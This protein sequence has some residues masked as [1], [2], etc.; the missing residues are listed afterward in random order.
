M[1]RSNTL[2]WRR[3]FR[4]AFMKCGVW[5]SVGFACFVSPDECPVGTFSNPR[6]LDYPS[7][8]LSPFTITT[9]L[10]TSISVGCIIC[11]K[12]CLPREKAAGGLKLTHPPPFRAWI[13]MNNT[14]APLFDFVSCTGTIVPTKAF[15]R[16]ERSVPYVET[17]CVCSS[18]T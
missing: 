18:V 3:G 2:V 9:F 4:R 17:T 10:P 15:L 5:I 12:G 13:Q 14:S 7:L 16:S 8:T 6:P 1:F 11:N